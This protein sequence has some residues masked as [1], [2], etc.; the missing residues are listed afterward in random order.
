M[1]DEVYCY[2]SNVSAKRTSY[3][4]GQ[5]TWVDQVNKLISDKH[6]INTQLQII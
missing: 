4:S 5:R 3:S 1:L 2:I 6:I